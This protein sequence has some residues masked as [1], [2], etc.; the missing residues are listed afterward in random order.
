MSNM[1]SILYCKISV[2]KKKCIILYLTKPL[3]LVTYNLSKLKR[4]REEKIIFILI[5]CV[6]R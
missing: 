2:K 1:K 6:M 5:V 4:M 3:T